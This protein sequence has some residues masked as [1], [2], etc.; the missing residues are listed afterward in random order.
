M[1]DHKHT[2]LVLSLL[3]AIGCMPP[4]IAAQQN[5]ENTFGNKDSSAQTPLRNQR[6]GRALPA[7]RLLGR[8]VESQ[9]GKHIG[10]LRDLIVSLESGRVL[11]AIIDQEG[12]GNRNRLA[13]PP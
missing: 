1:N 8:N 6:I 4:A 7:E 12:S 3:A 10:E 11:Y 2:L 5:D 13:V 9:D